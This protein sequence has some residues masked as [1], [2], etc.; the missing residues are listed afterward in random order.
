MREKSFQQ[1]IESI[2]ICVLLA[3]TV[4]SLAAYLRRPAPG[5][6]FYYTAKEAVTAR[7]DSRKVAQFVSP[8][9]LRLE[10]IDDRT[11]N[12][13]GWLVYSN[14]AHDVSTQWFRC[15]VESTFVTDIDLFLADPSRTYPSTRT[16]P[17]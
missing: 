13:Y 17:Q 12:V 3:V 9:D 4:I 2:T 11:T 10:K 14:A 15:T 6:T 5:T 16:K 8:V 1:R 7:V